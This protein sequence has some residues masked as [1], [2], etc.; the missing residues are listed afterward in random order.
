MAEMTTDLYRAVFEGTIVG[1]IVTDGVP[2]TGLLYPRLDKDVTVIVGDVESLVQTGG[3]TSLH[4]VD[5]W[6]EFDKCRYFYIPRD[7]PIPASLTITK[8]KRKRTNQAKT[9]RGFIT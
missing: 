9:G 3:G 7:T 6:F 8:G 1:D 2:A 5:G 4:D